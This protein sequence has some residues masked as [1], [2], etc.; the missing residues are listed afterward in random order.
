[1]REYPGKTNS[2]LR[3]LS[4]LEE[5][6]LGSKPRGGAINRNYCEGSGEPP[7]TTVQN[8]VAGARFS[9]LTRPATVEN[10]DSENTRQDIDAPG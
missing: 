2:W 8:L 1:M 3:T 10:R 7:G 6:R 9:L 4:F 5:D